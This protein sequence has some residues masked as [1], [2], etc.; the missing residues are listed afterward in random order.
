MTTDLTTTSTHD[1]TLIRRHRKKMKS[2][3]DQRNLNRSEEVT[4]IIRMKKE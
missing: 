1:N 2:K 4:M 3:E